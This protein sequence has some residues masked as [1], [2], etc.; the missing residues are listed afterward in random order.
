MGLMKANDDDILSSLNMFQS[1]LQYLDLKAVNSNNIGGSTLA[2]NISVGNMYRLPYPK[3]NNMDGH[4]YVEGYSSSSG[5]I[6]ENYSKLFNK[7]LT[8]K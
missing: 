1:K 3:Y 8:Y 4:F 7:F 2:N 5:V 6:C